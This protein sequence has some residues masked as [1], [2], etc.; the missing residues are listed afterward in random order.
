MS[1]RNAANF[2]MA[3]LIGI[4]S[5]VLLRLLMRTRVRDQH[6]HGA[7]SRKIIFVGDSTSQ[8]AGIAAVYDRDRP[9][10]PAAA[11]L[12]A[13]FEQVNSIGLRGLQ[14]TFPALR[15]D[16]DRIGAVANFFHETSTI[17]PR[18]RS[19]SH[20]ERNALSIPF[21]F[22]RDTHISH[23]TRRFSLQGNSHSDV[24]PSRQNE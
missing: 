6:H 16:V 3:V 13:L 23:G 22:E 18:C 15:V 24:N 9:G 2:K 1:R 7:R 17:R 12:D 4:R 11:Y 21:R 8:R 10:S 5:L 14:I 20:S 19:S